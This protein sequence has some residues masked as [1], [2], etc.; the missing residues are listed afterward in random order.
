MKIVI[1]RTN[2]HRSANLL[3]LEVAF[4]S[5]QIDP[6][7]KVG[8]T[9]FLNSHVHPTTTDQSCK[10]QGTFKINNMKFSASCT[11]NKIYLIYFSQPN[12]R[13]GAAQ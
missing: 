2:E 12:E 11:T 1:G 4:Q 8:P 5:K 10:V 13:N 7:E 3:N 9:Y 6:A